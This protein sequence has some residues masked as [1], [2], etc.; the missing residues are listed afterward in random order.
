MNKFDNVFNKYYHL[1]LKYGLKF[2]SDE[3]HVRDILQEVFLEVWKNEKYKYEESHLKS[4]LFN[5]V[6]NRCLNHLR[7][8]AVIKKHTD[9]ENFMIRMSEFDYFQSGGKSLIEYEEI[10]TVI[11]AIDSLSP[12]SKEVIQMSRFE[13]LRNVEIAEKL[14]IPIRTVETR[15]F[16]AL[17]KLRDILFLK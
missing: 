8:D 12:H 10:E 11:H 2:I 14:S 6:R 7:H 5:S 13:E 9:Q 15:L 1:L 3:D 17:S 16:R 4:Y